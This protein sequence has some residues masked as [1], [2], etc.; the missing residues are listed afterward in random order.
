MGATPAGAKD[1]LEVTLAKSSESL[2]E[3][4]GVKTCDVDGVGLLKIV[5]WT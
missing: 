3:E 5:K 1:A 2:V 4:D